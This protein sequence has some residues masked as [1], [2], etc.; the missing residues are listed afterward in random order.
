MSISGLG[1]PPQNFSE[2]QDELHFTEHVIPQI[3]SEWG[4]WRIVHKLLCPLVQGDALNPLARTRH[5][6]LPCKAALKSEGADA[7]FGESFS[8]YHKSDELLTVTLREMY[9][10]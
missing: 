8:I 1:Y 5:M 7:I 10:Q 4:I 2:I 9:Y 3:L 6:T